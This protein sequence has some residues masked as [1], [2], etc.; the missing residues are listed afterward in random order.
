MN[1]VKLKS[2]N[3]FITG[4]SC[5]V[6]AISQ[7]SLFAPMHR[8]NAPTF[9]TL[10]EVVK[11]TEEKDKSNIIKADRNV[12]QRLITAYQGRRNDF[13]IGGA[14]MFLRGE[15]LFISISVISN[16]H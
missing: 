2:K 7:L 13:G 4:W 10:Y 8:N 5:K 14:K 16:I 11:N 15:I 6:I 3:L 12:L 9:A 1:L